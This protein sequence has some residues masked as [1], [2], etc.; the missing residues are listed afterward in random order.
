MNIIPIKS[1]KQ[2]NI[3]E[4]DDLRDDEF[5]SLDVFNT[6]SERK[7]TLKCKFTCFK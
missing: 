1:P 4:A 3:L 6:V 2:R 7:V 5:T